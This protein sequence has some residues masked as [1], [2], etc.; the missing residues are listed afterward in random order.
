MEYDAKL[1]ITKEINM[2]ELRK[3]LEKTR[4]NKKTNRVEPYDPLANQIYNNRLIKTETTYNP[5]Y[6]LSAF[7]YR[8]TCR[9][10]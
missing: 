9:M 7:P 6:D 1:G 10:Q 8:A 2:K 4:K 3:S 5:I